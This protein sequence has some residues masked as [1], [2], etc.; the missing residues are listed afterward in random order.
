MANENKLVEKDAVAQ[1]MAKNRFSMTCEHRSSGRG[2]M[3]LYFSELY[4]D[5]MHRARYTDRG[6]DSRVW[7]VSMMSD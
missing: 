1:V 5:N 4:N 3:M 6:Y 2:Y 7:L